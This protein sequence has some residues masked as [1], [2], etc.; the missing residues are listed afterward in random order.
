MKIP[1]YGK[2]YILAI[3]SAIHAV[4]GLAMPNVFLFLGGLVLF[5]MFTLAV[6]ISLVMDELELEGRG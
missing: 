6:F 3:L 1:N 2:F 4:V 5:L